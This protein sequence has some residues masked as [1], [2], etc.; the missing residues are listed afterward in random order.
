MRRTNSLASPS[1]R[2]SG[3]ILVSI[4]TVSSLLSAVENPSA[5]SVPTSTSFGSREMVFPSTSRGIDSSLFTRAAT[6][7]GSR[8]ARAVLIFGKSSPYLGP[9]SLLS[10][11]TLYDSKDSGSWTKTSSLMFNSSLTISSRSGASSARPCLT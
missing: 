7:S 4:A 2:S 8:F 1:A 9:S 3:V 6:W 5:A 11:S 10:G